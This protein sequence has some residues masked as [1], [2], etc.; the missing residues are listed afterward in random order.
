[1]KQHIL[2]L[3]KMRG[4]LIKR[5]IGKQS[6]EVLKAHKFLKD[7]LDFNPRAT[8]ETATVFISKP[9]HK[10]KLELIC[11]SCPAGK[12]IL[13]KINSLIQPA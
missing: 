10:E 6:M 12:S 3:V 11:P 8:D 5:Q 7:W 4:L 1:M 13:T 2:K 9:E